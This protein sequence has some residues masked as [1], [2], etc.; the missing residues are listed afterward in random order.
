MATDFENSVLKAIEKIKA[1]KKKTSLEK[2]RN[3]VM[4]DI[5]QTDKEFCD[6]LNVMIKEKKIVKAL[7][8]RDTVYFDPQKGPIRLIHIESDDLSHLVKNAIKRLK[9]KSL[10]SDQIDENKIMEQIYSYIQNENKIKP[11]SSKEIKVKADIVSY[12]NASQQNN[13][14]EYNDIKV[15]SLD[16]ESSLF[17]LF[18]HAVGYTLFNIKQYE[19]IGMILLS[20]Q[21]CDNLTDFTKFANTVHLVAFSPFKSAKNALENI[22]HISEGLV[23][24][25]LYLFLDTYLPK[26]VSNVDRK[27][28]LLAIADSK[29]GNSINENANL[30]INCIYSGLVPDIMRGIRQHFNKFFK[31]LNQNDNLIDETK[32]SKSQLG[33]AHSY[34]RAK[35]KFNI[36]RVDNMIVQSI[37]ILDQLD[38]DINKFC[39]RLREWYSYHFPELYKLVPDNLLYA[40]VVK[41]FGD[42]KGIFNNATNSEE[43][44]KKLADILN[45]DLTLIRDILKIAKSSM[46]MDIS[47]LDLNMIGKFTDRVIAL[48]EFRKKL[49]V[50]LNDKMKC[51]APN[52]SELLGDT[53]SARLISHA[54]SLSNLAKCPASTI[55]ILGA[56]KALFRALKSR[57]GNTPKYGLLFHSSFISKTGPTNKGKI[58]RFLANK[59]AIASRIDCFS[60]VSCPI[61]GQFFKA[62]VENRIKFL[63][64]NEEPIKNHD[65]MNQAHQKAMEYMKNIGT[66]PTSYIGGKKIKKKDKRQHSPIESNSLLLKKEDT[67]SSILI[68]DEE[69][70]QHAT[71]KSKKRKME[72]TLNHFEIN[73]SILNGKV[74]N[75]SLSDEVKNITNAKFNKRKKKKMLD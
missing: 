25:D 44:K 30:G 16:G 5:F 73:T 54:G 39:M 35:I 23:H 52:L 3:I 27:K 15:L 75:Y 70:E 43:L 47:P 11:V 53:V 36:N 2:I 26:N 22:N 57:S 66:E 62:Q 21:L 63:E 18:E 28:V 19:E 69:H 45:H 13:N 49:S 74:E 8:S 24:E 12:V 65:L 59:C 33:L 56:E 10:K 9:Q 7:K 20:K 60:D 29:L 55:Q 1:F 50:Y 42:R 48:G 61:Y 37:A 41:C 34:S 46:G 32:E 51:V 68:E 38:K 67:E 64:N 14:R 4:R 6:K 72:A 58:S 71:K 31:N 17:I 40:R